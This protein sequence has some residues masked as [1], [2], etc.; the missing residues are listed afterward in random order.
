MFWA[1]WFNDSLI[2]IASEALN[3]NLQEKQPIL[4]FV[5]HPR[6]FTFC[7]KATRH[8]N[9]RNKLLHYTDTPESFEKIEKTVE[10]PTCGLWS[11]NNFK[12]I[13][14]D[15]QQAWGTLN[16]I[17][18]LNKGVQKLLNT[19]HVMFCSCNASMNSFNAEVSE[20]TWNTIFY[21]AKSGA[22]LN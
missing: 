6:A 1:E 14:L 20:I 18:S 8:W 12:I 10:I 16:N 4:I 15:E 2:S 9:Y 5:N 19:L 22:T 17:I 7:E 13:S 21:L 3:D 11:Y